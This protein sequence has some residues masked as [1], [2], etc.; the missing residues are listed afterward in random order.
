MPWEKDLSWCRT[1]I[2]IL[3]RRRCRRWKG[4]RSTPKSAFD[5][6][7]SYGDYHRMRA[8]ICVQLGKD[9]AHVPFNRVLRNHQTV[10]YYFVGATFSYHAQ[11]LNFAHRQSV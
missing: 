6:A 5:E 3:Q 1:S 2:V 7:P 11:H 9:A 8:V 4:K 10:G